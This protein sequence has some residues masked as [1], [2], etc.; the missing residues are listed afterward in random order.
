MGPYVQGTDRRRRSAR[1]VG[2]CYSDDV[3]AVNVKLLD[4]MASMMAD[5][6][7]SRARTCGEGHGLEL[8]CSLQAEW[9]GTG[10]QVLAARYQAFSFFIRCATI[11]KFWEPQY[12]YGNN[13]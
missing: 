7:L 8:W 2:F 6:L 12:H 13:T 5:S 4:A 11:D 1:S 10:D 9:K 3:T